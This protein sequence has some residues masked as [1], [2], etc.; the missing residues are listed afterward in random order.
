MLKAIW[1]YNYWKTYPP[2]KSRSWRTMGSLATQR[3][4]ILPLL[5]NSKKSEKIDSAYCLHVPLS[6]PCNRLNFLQTLYL[7]FNSAKSSMKATICTW[8]FECFPVIMDIINE[9][10]GNSDGSFRN[11]NR[12]KGLEIP[13]KMTSTPDCAKKEHCLPRS[14]SLSMDNC[15]SNALPCCSWLR[16]DLNDITWSFSM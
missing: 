6:V 1:I 10:E 12:Y 2:E 15:A 9:T 4:H 16:C 13:C 11:S 7:W 3:S 5:R 8:S 14:V